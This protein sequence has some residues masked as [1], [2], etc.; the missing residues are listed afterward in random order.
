MDRWSRQGCAQ[1]ATACAV[2]PAGLVGWLVV[3]VVLA[4]FVC[5]L[6]LAWRLAP[7]IDGPPAAWNVLSGDFRRLPARLAEAAA[8]LSST[9]HHLSADSAGLPAPNTAAFS[10]TR[11]AADMS[12]TVAVSSPRSYQS[13]DPEWT[14]PENVSASPARAINPVVLPASD[15]AVH[16]LWEQNDRIYHAVR[17][18]GQW[19]TPLSVATG[20]RPSG[21]L[22]AD[23][24]LHVVFSNE[25]AGRY[26]VFYVA[27][28]ND[29]W[30]LPRLV[31]KTP[32]MSTFPSLA[33]DRAGVVH[34]AW[35]DTSPGFSII[36][37][38][39]LDLTWLNEPLRNA[40][41]TAPVLA[42]DGASNDLHLAY[43]ATGI[44]TSAREIL[45]L[46]GGKYN[47]SLPENISISPANESLGVAMA[48]APDGTTHLAWQEHVGNKAHIRY[49]NGRRGAWYAP[50]VVSDTAMDAREPA[51]LV[52]QERQLSLAWRQADTIA[53]RVR[54]LSSGVWSPAKDLVSNPMGLSGPVLAGA[55]AGDLHLT[56]S[57]WSTDSERDIFYSQHAP[58]VGPKAFLPGVVIGRR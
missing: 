26:N 10:E 2:R 6:A 35:A 16:M 4:G 23:G 29:T 47:W 55:P 17:R 27:W 36:Y 12:D 13:S 52:T 31:S 39:W 7:A 1:R 48:C 49:V 41:G 34:A 38:G 37:H 54:S 56:W 30:T 43:Q 21:G 20:Q 44:S 9:V 33:V 19:T 53:Y 42:L 45:H 57:A 32:G 40:R 8:L 18:A 28:A 11:S 46:Q 22:T 50:E 3:P 58:L 24:V 25:F 51:V 5:G 14:T 15:G